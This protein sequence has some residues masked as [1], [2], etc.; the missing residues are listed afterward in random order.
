MNEEIKKRMIINRNIIQR[1]K[2]RKL[3]LYGHIC[4]MEDSRLVNEVVLGEM[5]G[6]TNRGR[7]HRKWL[8]EVKEWCNEEIY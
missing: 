6:K 4:R 7:P 1:I 8:D 3:K 2:E 5:A